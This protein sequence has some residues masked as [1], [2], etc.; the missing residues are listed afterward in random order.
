MHVSYS[1]KYIIS[2]EALIKNYNLN[3]LL[4]GHD[5]IDKSILAVNITFFFHHQHG[6]AL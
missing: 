1:G 4:Y 2:C 6:S 3:L 5:K